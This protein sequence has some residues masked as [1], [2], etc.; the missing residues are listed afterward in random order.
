MTDFA[1]LLWRC[2]ASLY[3]EASGAAAQVSGRELNSE[4]ECGPVAGFMSSN[5]R[6]W[7]GWR[8]PLLLT[9]P[10]STTKRLR[11]RTTPPQHEIVHL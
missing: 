5:R 8:L 6:G 2:S 1:I 11:P 3:A 10:A 4:E 7:P 9:A